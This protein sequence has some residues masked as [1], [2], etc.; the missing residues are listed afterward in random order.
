MKSDK[1]IIF[2]AGYYS[3]ISQ[4]FEAYLKIEIDL[5]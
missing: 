1:Y 3:S 5:L 2:L 4:D